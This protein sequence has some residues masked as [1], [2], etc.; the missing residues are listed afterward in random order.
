MKKQYIRNTLIGLGLLLILFVGYQLYLE[1]RP[2]IHLLLD[3]RASRKEWMREIPFT[4]S[5]CC[6]YFDVIDQFDVC[7]TRYS[8]FCDRC[9]RWPKLWSI[10]RNSYQCNRQCT[11]KYLIDRFDAT[12]NLYGS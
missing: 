6:V 8:Y 9:G 10:S 4:R 2:D 7:G 1:Y 12:F 11:W 3:P 5:I